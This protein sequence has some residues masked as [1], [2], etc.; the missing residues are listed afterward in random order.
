MTNYITM[1]QLTQ[2]LKAS[3]NTSFLHLC[4]NFRNAIN[5][6]LNGGAA[7]YE[8]AARFTKNG[9]PFVISK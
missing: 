2:I 3:P 8:I 6:E 5:Y 9:R 1:K 4:A 7:D